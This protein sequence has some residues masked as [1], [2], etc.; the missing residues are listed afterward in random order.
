MFKRKDSEVK[1]PSY[2]L[3]CVFPSIHNYSNKGATVKMTV[4]IKCI[5]FF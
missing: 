3:L 4:L 1:T 5:F 2:L